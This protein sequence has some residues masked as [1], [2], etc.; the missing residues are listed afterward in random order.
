M[1]GLASPPMASASPTIRGDADDP[2]SRGYICPKAVALQDVHDRSRPPAAAHAAHRRIAGS[3]SA[4]TRRSRSQ[5]TACTPCAAHPR[6]RRHRRVRGNPTTCIRSARFSPARCSCAR[7]A[8]RTATRP[9]PST[10]SPRM[11]AAHCRCSGTQLLHAGPR[12]RPHRH[13]LVLGANPLASNG[14]L[15]TAPGMK[16]RLDPRA[17]R[18]RLVVIDPRRSET[19]ERADAHHFIRPGTDALLLARAG[20]RGAA[21]G[22]TPRAPRR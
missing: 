10:S 8:R 22:A 9:R 15:M 3:A 17:R 21:E 18:T 4:G 19:A 1:C 12:P 2:L 5:W 16:H 14:S 13:L 7:S 20:E 11:L 6:P